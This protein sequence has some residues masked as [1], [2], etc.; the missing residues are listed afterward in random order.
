MR[1]GLHTGTPLLTNEGYIGGDVHRAARIAAAGHGGQVLV[2]STTAPLAE[3]ELHDLGEH[4][5][6]DLL[7]LSASTSWVGATSHR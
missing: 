6:K 7:L 2:S 3:L 4:R 5:F 1:I